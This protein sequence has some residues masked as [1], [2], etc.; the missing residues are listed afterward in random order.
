M[1]IKLCGFTRIEDIEKIIGLPVSAA[2]FVFHKKSERYVTPPAAG[3]MAL[4]LK[5]S[6]IKATGIFVDYDPESI[7]E[8]VKSAHL[9]MVQV[10]SSVTAGKLCSVIPVIECVRIG[11]RA[12]PVFPEPLPGGMVLFDKYSSESHGGTGKSF[13]REMINGYRFR[14][15]MIVAGGVNEGNIKD[16][17]REVKPGGL[18]IS[19]GIEITK[20]IKSLDKI[21]KIMKAIEEAE[22]DINA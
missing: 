22:N 4:L 20:G 13:N 18:D 2:G 3:E 9:D 16:I 19:S 1:F 15:K 11:D 10:Y 21:L 6:G 7:M 8:I 17:I 12:R 5:G 14:D